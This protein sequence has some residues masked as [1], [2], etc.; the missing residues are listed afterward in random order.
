MHSHEA[1]GNIFEGLLHDVLLH[2]LLDTL[3][4][5]PFLFLTYLLMELI[6]HKATDRVRSFMKRSG[7]FA[8]LAGGALGA[9]PQCGFSS[10]TANLYCA[11]IVSLGTVVAVFLSTSDEMLPILISSAMPAGLIAFILVYK[12]IVGIAVGFLTDLVIRLL[13][14][15]GEEIHIHELCEEEGCQCEGG[16]LRSAIRHTLSITL[17]IFVITLAINSLVFFIGEEAITHILPDVPVVSHIIAAI[18]GLIPNCASSIALTQLFGAGALTLGEMLAGLFAGSGVGL[19]VL[20]KMNKKH[21]RENLIT[22]AILVASGV[23][24]GLLADALNVSSWLLG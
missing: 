2:G 24:F 18:F 4:L 12:I 9:I 17:F 3:K 11:R 14:R 10:V 20:F 1:H 6:E 19:L 8:P 15:G 23:V 16:V 13:R 7:S 5:L 21:I 22:V